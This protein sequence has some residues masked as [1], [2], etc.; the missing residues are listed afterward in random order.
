MNPKEWRLK[1]DLTL[2]DLSQKM[3]YSNTGY[4]S[5]VENGVKRPSGRLLTE[6]DRL[7]NGIVRPS[8]FEALTVQAGAA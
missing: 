6:Y 2:E 5:E 7:S 8:D 3:G 4:L 1:N